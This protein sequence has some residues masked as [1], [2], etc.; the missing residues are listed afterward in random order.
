MLPHRNPPKVCIRKLSV[1][2][3]VICG[4]K[5]PRISRVSSRILSSSFIILHSACVADPW[6][7]YKIRSKLLVGRDNA[8]NVA[9]F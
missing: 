9:F 6:N 7:F 8:I 3:R 2:I 4:D 1:Q 5:N